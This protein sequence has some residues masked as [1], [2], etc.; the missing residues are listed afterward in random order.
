MGGEEK[1][2]E[3]YYSPPFPKT[4]SEEDSQ[5][6]FIQR[7]SQPPLLFNPS[8]RALPRSPIGVFVAWKSKGS[9]YLYAQLACRVKRQLP[10]KV[11]LFQTNSE[12]FPYW[13]FS[14]LRDPH[15]NLQHVSMEGDGWEL[16]EPVKGSFIS[17]L[18]GT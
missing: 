17:K 16:R 5:G 10:A 4:W 15:L 8:V 1:A 7:A 13:S 11:V 9:F 18:V 6:F 2:A 14:L 3:I 12:T